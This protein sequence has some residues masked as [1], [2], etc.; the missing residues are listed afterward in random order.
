M[1]AAEWAARVPAKRFPVARHELDEQLL[2]TVPAYGDT[3]RRLVDEYTT[4][5]LSDRSGRTDHAQR[6][7]R[8]PWLEPGRLRGYAAGLSLGGLVATYSVIFGRSR[9]L[10]RM[11]LDEAQ[12]Y[13]AVMLVIAGLAAV[14]WAEPA[15]RGEPVPRRHQIMGVVQA[16]GGLPIAALLL[17]RLGDDGINLGWAVLAGAGAVVSLVAMVPVVRARVASPP[18][19]PASRPQAGPMPGGPSPGGL[20][21]VGPSPGERFGALQRRT[22]EYRDL[23]ADAFD[24]L[25]DAERNVLA[26]DHAAAIDTLRRRGIDPG[27]ADAEDYLPGDL[28]LA[29]RTRDLSQLET[30]NPAG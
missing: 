24:A 17:W 27:A 26:A 16:L 18:P 19:T 20:S 11:D 15:R 30:N 3:V 1:T 13:I 7:A 9:G 10:G 6:K 29:A 21:P 8:G 25:T 14:V 4:A 5:V 28:L 22:E 23:V 12:P 2:R